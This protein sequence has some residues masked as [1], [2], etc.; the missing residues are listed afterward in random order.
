MRG[1]ERVTVT[2]PKQVIDR[3]RA[4]IE[5][6]AAETVS[7]YVAD[8]LMERFREESVDL[9]LTDME[10]V[11]EPTTEAAREWARDTIRL[12]RGE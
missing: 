3:I 8:T 12:A 6:G 4:N 5:T 9:L 10:A 11:G 1:T 7:G 2:L